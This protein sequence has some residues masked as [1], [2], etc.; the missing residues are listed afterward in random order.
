[1]EVASRQAVSLLASW[2]RTEVFFQE[3]LDF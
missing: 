1:M 3:L 2:A